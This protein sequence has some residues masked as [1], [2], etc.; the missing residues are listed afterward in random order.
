MPLL[1]IIGVDTTG[2]SFY[3]AFAFLSGET[4]EDYTWVLERLKTLYE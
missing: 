2:R 1:D 4:E 3:I